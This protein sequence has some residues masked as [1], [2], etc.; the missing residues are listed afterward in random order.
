M[1]CR[2]GAEQA[3]PLE[4]RT[5]TLRRGEVDCSI[6]P[7]ERSAA[8]GLT[9]PADTGEVDGSAP[10]ISSARTGREGT[11]SWHAWFKRDGKGHGRDTMT[12]YLLQ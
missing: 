5:L 2:R 12:V 3:C 1:E 7:A 4:D 11:V 6:T 8:V 10:A 9:N